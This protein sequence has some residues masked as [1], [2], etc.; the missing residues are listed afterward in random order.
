MSFLT[1]KTQTKCIIGM[2]RKENRL[3]LLPQ[4]FGFIQ[5]ACYAST[6]IKTNY[7]NDRDQNEH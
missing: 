3:V 2:L 1:T 7:K 5:H 6:V 4:F